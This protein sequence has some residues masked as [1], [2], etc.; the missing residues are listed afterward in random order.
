MAGPPGSLQQQLEAVE[1]QADDVDLATTEH[2]QVEILNTFRITLHGKTLQEVADDQTSAILFKYVTGTSVGTAVAATELIG[3]LANIKVTENALHA[4]A[5][6]FS[7]GILKLLPRGLTDD[8]GSTVLKAMEACVRCTS[9]RMAAPLLDGPWIGAI[10]RW[11]T[12]PTKLAAKL[13]LEAVVIQCKK[14]IEEDRNWVMC[15]RPNVVFWI[16]ALKADVTDAAYLGLALYTVN[17]KDEDLAFLANHLK[18]GTVRLLVKAAESCYG[19][20][21]C[22][23]KAELGHTSLHVML[24][25]ER[26]RVPLKIQSL[27]GRKSLIAC[28]VSVMQPQTDNA[29]ALVAA[30]AFIKCVEAKRLR[31]NIFL[32]QRPWPALVDLLARDCVLC[33]KAG[34]LAIQV[35]LERHGGDVVIPPMLTAVDGQEGA[36]AGQVLAKALMAAITDRRT[37]KD[38]VTPTTLRPFYWRPL[39]AQGCVLHDTSVTIVAE[40]AKIKA[41]AQALVAEQVG[42]ML[43]PQMCSGKPHLVPILTRVLWR[44]QQHS[45]PTSRKTPSCSMTPNGCP[46]FW[47][48]QK[49]CPQRFRRPLSR[50]LSS[51]SAKV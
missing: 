22:R 28:C 31:A 8:Q 49:T 50:Y 44:T 19:P 37:D 6:K 18:V 38:E 3:E 29:T 20:E 16:Q 51:L 2:R 40:A 30:T 32:D 43:L 26:C 23:C 21:G 24:V 34:A 4:V 48:A 10:V 5:Y 33:K 41:A 25:L 7:S 17:A 13:L 15:Y 12:G 39:A 11:L 1:A 9:P 45:R 46:P 27:I 35:L 47:P 36:P 42:S 14:G